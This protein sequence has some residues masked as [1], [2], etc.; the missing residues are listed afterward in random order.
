MATTHK[1]FLG[2]IVDY[3]TGYR[4]GKLAN[5]DGACTF[6]IDQAFTTSTLTGTAS[7]TLLED[8]AVPTGLKC[9]ITEY[10]IR[11]G[12]TAF[13]ANVKI[14]DSNSTPVDFVTVLAANTTG[15]YC[16]TCGT[17]PTGLTQEAALTANSGG[18]ASKGLVLRSA[19]TQSLG[20]AGSVY[21]RGY[22]AP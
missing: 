1:Q 18:T 2:K 3:L 22:F 9:Y 12:S 21:I 14:S 15:Y 7:V 10:V 13:A 20:S 6:E 19:S 5:T 8:A 11:F 16:N 4:R 17:L